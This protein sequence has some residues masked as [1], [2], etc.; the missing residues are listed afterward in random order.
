YCSDARIALSEPGVAPSF[1]WATAVWARP[2]EGRM[3]MSEST[4]SDA[5]TRSR[6]VTVRRIW[7]PGRGLSRATAP[8]DRLERKDSPGRATGLRPYQP[9][10]P[11]TGCRL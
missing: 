9:H 10:A 2:T 5:A 6:C 3:A 8:Q 11:A 7:G 1:R 4:A